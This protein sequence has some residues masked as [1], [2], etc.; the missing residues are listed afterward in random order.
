MTYIPQKYIEHYNRWYK[1]TYTVVQYD[2]N[3]KEHKISKLG[4]ETYAD[5]VKDVQKSN[6]WLEQTGKSKDVFFKIKKTSPADALKMMK[7]RF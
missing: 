2:K 1:N 6:E 4:I 7:E 5:A 3:N